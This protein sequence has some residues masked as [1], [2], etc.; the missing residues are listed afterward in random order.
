[1]NALAPRSIACTGQIQARPDAQTL[2]PQAG[3]R[4]PAE[5]TAGKT[6]VGVGGV[7]GGGRRRT[8]GFLAMAVAMCAWAGFALSARAIGHSHLSI[9]EVGA[10]RYV[11]PVLLLA[12]WWPRAWRE[13]RRSNPRACLLI[14]VGGGLPFFYLTAEGG[15]YSS[16]SHISIVNLGATPLLL[17]L[18]AHL[19]NRRVS[20]AGRAVQV[21]RI[22]RTGRT[23]RSRQSL[24][25]EATA[26]RFGLG[27]IA[28]GLLTLLAATPGAGPGLA[29]LAGSAL[30]WTLYSSAQPDA[31]LSPLTTVLVMCTPSALPAL[32]MALL[33]A[34]HASWSVPA[35]ELVVY[36]LVQ[37]VVSGIVSAVSYSVALQRLGVRTC[38]LLGAFTPVMVAA[39][40]VLMLGEGLNLFAYFGL[41]LV[42]L[43]VVAGHRRHRSRVSPA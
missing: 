31:A 36:L 17:V 15:R 29:L 25:G 21:G 22:G 39:L 14:A 30:L 4:L 16:A 40:S 13:V 23:A 42:I 2:A 3:G 11:V 1:M 26:Q 18:L 37:G 27:A 6:V 38:A 32:L 7:V 5:G 35:G 24:P 19:R 20:R 33:S 41:G 12:P 9:A 10:I 43:G 8:V 34:H 28:L